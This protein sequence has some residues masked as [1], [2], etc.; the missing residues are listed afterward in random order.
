MIRKEKKHSLFTIY[1]FIYIY[2]LLFITELPR[3]RFLAS[4]S[5]QVNVA[6]ARQRGILS[7]II[8]T[9]YTRE[10]QAQRNRHRKRNET[11]SSDPWYVL[12]WLF[13]REHSKNTHA[14]HPSGLFPT[15]S[16]RILLYHLIRTL[17]LPSSHR[18]L[19]TFFVSSFSSVPPSVDTFSVCFRRYETNRDGRRVFS[20]NQPPPIHWFDL[21]MVFLLLFAVPISDSIRFFIY[22]P[23]SHVQTDLNA[24]PVG[25]GYCTFPSEI[26]FAIVDTTLCFHFAS[27]VWL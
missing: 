21:R 7:S 19:I 24:L 15:F 13:S 10:K 9:N 25:S 11:R 14:S 6:Q 17:S 23:S 3:S 22:S 26:Q 2:L 12:R 5:G 27:S 1:I 18:R 16:S 20:L 4:S 8:W